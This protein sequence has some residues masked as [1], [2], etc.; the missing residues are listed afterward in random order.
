[1]CEGPE[2]V[3]Y[4]GEAGSGME[5]VYQNPRNTSR[6]RRRASAR[7]VSSNPPTSQELSRLDE[8][9]AAKVP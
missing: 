7:D 4:R 8:V 5:L 2:D 1:V 6:R 3:V 9:A